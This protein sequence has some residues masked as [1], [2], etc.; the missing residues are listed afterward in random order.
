MSNPI[1]RWPRQVQ[2]VMEEAQQRQPPETA[3]VRAVLFGR[4]S[5][6]DFRGAPQNSDKMC[7]FIYVYI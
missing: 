7:R 3:A 1:P 6:I 2:E 4:V 5:R